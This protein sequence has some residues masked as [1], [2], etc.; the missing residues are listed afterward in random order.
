MLFFSR[1][2]VIQLS[3]LDKQP[4]AERTKAGYGLMAYCT[5][6][7]TH[8]CTFTAKHLPLLLYFYITVQYCEEECIIRAKWYSTTIPLQCCKI[9]ISVILQCKFKIKHCIACFDVYLWQH[10]MN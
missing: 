8:C 5:P 2:C 1:V 10:T 6:T 7:E 9:A 3:I 4:L